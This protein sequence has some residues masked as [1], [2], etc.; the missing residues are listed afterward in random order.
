[1]QE[2]INADYCIYIRPD[3]TGWK[4]L[5]FSKFDEIHKCG[6]IHGQ[7]VFTEEWCKEF[8][9]ELFKNCKKRT[10]ASAS[11]R[12]GKKILPQPQ[13]SFTDLSSYLDTTLEN[14]HDWSRISDSDYE[15]EY[16]SSPEF[17][18][19]KQDLTLP[20]NIRT[21]NIRSNIHDIRVISS[22]S[23][24]EEETAYSDIDIPS[25]SYSNF[26]NH[27]KLSSKNLQN[28]SNLSS[29]L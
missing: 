28:P 16:N 4:V 26:L 23:T 29:S 3:L 21:V 5:D 1:M 14:N 10:T 15:M 8:W 27:R 19:H 13:V 9:E 25:G 6:L 11:S 7:K 22:P 12:I 24:P 20:S 2:V 17:S 18:N